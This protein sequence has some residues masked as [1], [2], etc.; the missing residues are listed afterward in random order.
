MTTSTAKLYRVILPVADL[1]TAEP[2]YARLLGDAADSP[3][4]ADRG[5]KN[6]VG[7]F[8]TIAYGF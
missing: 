7:T 3:I 4:V 5:A 2:F 1:R 6:Q 8:L